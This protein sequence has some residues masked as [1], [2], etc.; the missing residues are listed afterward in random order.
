[1]SDFNPYT[2]YID[3]LYLQ[4]LMQPFSITFTAMKFLFDYFK[5]DPY[6]RYMLT[7]GWTDFAY[8]LITLEVNLMGRDVV[9]KD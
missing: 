4:D 2:Y 6:A 9:E 8:P 1:M 3:S 7:T 5:L